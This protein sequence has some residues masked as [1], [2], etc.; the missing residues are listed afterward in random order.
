M[1][2]SDDAK[3]ETLYE[4]L[5][6]IQAGMMHCKSFYKSRKTNAQFKHYQALETEFM[7]RIKVLEDTMK[8][9]ET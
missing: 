9:T 5:D 3:L 1:E 4:V 8:E 6:Y 2:N 7:E